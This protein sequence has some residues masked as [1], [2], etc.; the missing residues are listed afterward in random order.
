MQDPE[1]ILLRTKE[2]CIGQGTDG[3][4]EANDIGKHL[5][6]KSLAADCWDKMSKGVHEK[7]AAAA[8]NP[9]E[10]LKLIQTSRYSQTIR[11][12]GRVACNSATG[13]TSMNVD[14]KKQLQI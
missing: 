13:A 12:T 3:C 2:V 4:V 8:L 10:S 5:V 9:A 1:R 7:S 11:G 14:T 6:Q